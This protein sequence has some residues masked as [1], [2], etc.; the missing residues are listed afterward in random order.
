[1]KTCDFSAGLYSTRAS[2]PKW[3]IEEEKQQ[4]KALDMLIPEGHEAK[5]DASQEAG[6]WAALL[7]ELV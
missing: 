2:L 3:C 7:G 5:E 6:P 4:E 1:M